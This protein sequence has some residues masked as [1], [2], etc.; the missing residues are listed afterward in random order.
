[1]QAIDIVK[2]EPKTE[3]EA[4]MRWANRIQSELLSMPGYGRKI[5]IKYIDKINCTGRGRTICERQGEHSW[6]NHSMDKA[7]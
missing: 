4:F 7:Y 5:E 6:F 1:M 3:Q 2:A